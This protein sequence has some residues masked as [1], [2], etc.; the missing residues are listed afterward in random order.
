MQRT[1]MHPSLWLILCHQIQPHRDVMT[2]YDFIARLL[3]ELSPVLAQH[4]RNRDNLRVSHKIDINDVLT[5]ADEAIQRQIVD[6]IHAAYPDDFILAEE[7]NMS[8]APMDHDAR[9]WIIDP[10]DGT[11]NFV[12]GLFPVFGISVAFAEGG[13]V[14]AGGVD[15]SGLGKRFLARVGDGATCNGAPISC[16]PIDALSTGRV[17]ID[18]G[19][20]STRQ[21]AIDGFRDVMAR[22][23]QVRCHCAAVVGLCSVAAGEMDAYLHTSLHPWDFAAS[24]LIIEEAGGRVTKLDGTNVDLF[25]SGNGLL[26][27]NALI[28]DECLGTLR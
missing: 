2:E 25:A 14:R 28:H 23:G 17:E 15:M 10:I 9:C 4:Y 20:P 27:S 21:P 12:R 24:M 18:F 13:R 19:H 11:Q 26:A 3:E 5:E 1:W 16:S 7:S 8:I 6:R 22:A